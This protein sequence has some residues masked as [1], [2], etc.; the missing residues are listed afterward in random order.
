MAT[1][2]VYIQ[3]RLPSATS[4]GA[5]YDFSGH[6]EFDSLTWEQNDQGKASTLSMNIYSVLGSG[7]GHWA[8]Y[9]GATEA[10]K[11][12]AALA[13]P[14]YRLK[15][16]P[17]TE[18][19]IRDVSTSPHTILWGGVVNRVEESRDGG[20]I[21]GSLEAVDYTELLSESVALEYT[22]LGQSTIKQVLTSQTYSYTVTNAERTDGQT[23][24][25]ITGPVSIGSP[26]NRD[27]TVGDT[28]VVNIDDNTFDGI[29]TLTSVKPST[30]GAFLVKYTQYAQVA[31]V[32]LKSVT[33]TMKS[34]GFLTTDNAPGLDS[35]IRVL[36]ANIE[37]LN[38]SFKFSPQSS[39]IKRNVST[40][41]R[42]GTLVTL[43]TSASH[44]YSQGQTITVA[45][46]AG[47]T[48]YE[49]LN[50]TWEIVDAPTAGSI[51]FNTTA[52]GTITGN[53]PAVV[54]TIVS[55]GFITP[56]PIKGGT[57]G[58]NVQTIVSK[59]AGAFYLNSG[60][61]DGANNLTIDLY[62]RSTKT[63]DLIANGIFEDGDTT[64]WTI[65]AF[66]VDTVGNTGPFGVGN[67]V[68]YTGSDHQDVELASGSRIPVTAGQ[69]YLLSWRQKSGKTNKSHLHVKFY[70][71]GG[72]VVGN[73]HGYDICKTDLPD[74]EW[75]RN[76]GI[77]IVPAT[78]A[79][80]TPV[81]H[82]EDF[83]SS[84]SV[85]YTDIQVIKLTGAF[86]FSDK[87][88]EDNAWYNSINGTGVD[89]RDFE[90]PSSPSE[91]GTSSN[92]LY[93]Y[94]PYTEED[95][96]TG[97]KKITNY[98]NTYDFVQG[99][100]EAGGKRIEASQ[101]ANDA[102]TSELALATAQ[103]FFK[104]K[105]QILRSYEFDHISG[106]LNVGDVVPFIWNEL[107][108]AEALIVR[109]QVGYLIGQQM[110]YKVQLGGDIGL[111]RNTMYLV[112]Q[113]LREITGE[114]P[115]YA[116][117]ST[118]TAGSPTAGG[119]VVPAAPTA[120][121]S[122]GFV[123]VSWRYPA[124][125]LK[126]DSFGGFVVLRSNDSGATWVKASTQENI[127]DAA[128]PIAPD[129]L[130]A[131]FGDSAVVTTDTYYYKIAAIDKST[132]Q[133]VIT[134]YSTTTDPVVP[135][136][137]PSADF[138]NAYSGLG[139]NVPK[140]VY[141]VNEGTSTFQLTSSSSPIA[142]PNA[143]YPTG[144][145]VF[146]ELDSKMYRVS[147]TGVWVRAAIDRIDVSID[148]TIGIAA[149][150]ISTGTLDAANIAVTN[151]RAESIKSGDISL[152]SNDLNNLSTITVKDEAG[153]DV[154]TWNS[155]G[156][157]IYPA[158]SSGEQER[159]VLHNGELRVF[160]SDGV[161]TTAID[162]E[163]INASAI[164]VGALPGGA[165][166]I[167]NSSFELAPFGFSATTSLPDAYSV[168]VY[169]SYTN[170]SL[171]NATQPLTTAS[172]TAVANASGTAIVYTANN[173]FAQGDYVT[174]TGL[175]TAGY[176]LVNVPIAS[177]TASNFTV[178]GTATG[179]TSS[180]GTATK[181]GNIVATTYGYA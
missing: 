121:A 2:R 127:T 139:I 91:A 177:R 4:Q 93:L 132:D 57:L 73:S 46:T 170:V 5:F 76:Y 99:V 113:T 10:D 78:A 70:D 112:E 161:T 88:L 167:P 38:T 119:V 81:L 125:V 141:S 155:S 71:A 152:T 133:P 98:R 16:Y 41:S 123:G 175:T 126:S 1:I 111:Q 178:A 85:Y 44:A 130:V 34:Y 115:L 137:Y 18:I 149:D 105:G 171:V 22:S 108:V 158:G 15:I 62:A 69:Q 32:A 146:A 114:T 33:G 43:T 162:G 100:W 54:G 87:P 106:P 124:D 176:N 29:H 66:S 129:T 80:M 104:S 102:T 148:G 11:I 82:H 58:Q 143:Q 169:K 181:Y 160:G 59:G 109:R 92:R 30:G 144:Q 168:R 154:A 107:G 96:L 55:A 101:V 159:V 97:G 75:G 74:N 147:S 151:L 52:T 31:N 89:L 157:S 39:G 60:V 12:T 13:D 128:D 116:P 23:T 90:S 142:L 79:T 14:F 26:Y 6:V 56:T 86:G 164:R 48:G 21:T 47:P 40:I 50:G 37:D 77:A 49:S 138:T 84:Y 166:S 36:A 24:L 83:S 19:Q 136:E 64:G 95:Y 120:A 35:R 153:L 25:T 42:T 150:R 122:T 103:D 174:I 179:A 180:G 51:T 118:P 20:A 65:G 3:P 63:I 67:S 165:N 172:I 7:A 110:F 61:L 9:A 163:G 156:L 173:T 27:I 28:F 53:S 140:V 8:T 131:E 45:L 72:T 135:E 134:D 117:S 68:Y 94:A 145:M 17:K